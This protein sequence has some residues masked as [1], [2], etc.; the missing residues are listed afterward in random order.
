MDC[1]NDVDEGAVVAVSSSPLLLL[2]V[3]VVIS[4]STASERLSALVDAT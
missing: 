1:S 2:F 4:A 3:E